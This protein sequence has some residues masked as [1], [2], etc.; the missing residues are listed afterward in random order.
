NSV[1]GFQ[2]V[3]SST[4]SGAALRIRAVNSTPITPPNGELIFLE[5]ESAM[6]TSPMQVLSDPNASGGQ[7]IT[8]AP[9]NN[10]KDSP[11]STGQA[12]VSFNVSTAGT[13]KVWARV[14]APS[15][16]DDSFWVR[17]DGGTW[18][19]WNEIAPGS[20]WHWDEVHNSDAG[21]TVVNFNLATGNHT[22][23]IAYREDGTKLIAF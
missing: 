4:T 15:V 18:I 9:G 20:S 7:F 16:E 14:I 21:S 1:N 10:S 22:L 8:V 23:T 5:A 19:K 12:T 17:M 13:Y 3:N 11:P 2:V 6:I